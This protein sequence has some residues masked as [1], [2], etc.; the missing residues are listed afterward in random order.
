[1]ETTQPICEDNKLL[2]ATPCHAGCV[3]PP[4]NQVTISDKRYNE[5]HLIYR[6]FTRNG[7][8]MFVFDS[9]DEIC[10]LSSRSLDAFFDFCGMQKVLLGQSHP[11][12]L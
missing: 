11:L 12:I 10:E 9:Y 7:F 2:Y 4:E 8:K 1:M 3:N 5:L 6:G